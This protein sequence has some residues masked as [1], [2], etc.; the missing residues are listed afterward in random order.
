MTSPGD[1]EQ[2]N[3]TEAMTR[4]AGSAV[5]LDVRNPDETAAGRAREAM[6][7]P[8]PELGT[9]LDELDPT[10]PI[11]AVCKAGG[12]SQMAAELL[13]AAGFDV[14]NLAG[15]M[16]AW[17]SAGLDVIDNAGEPGSIK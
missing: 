6:L 13:A 10:V 5:L 12:R 16:Q 14:V 17:A 11:V 1:I 4:I 2:I 15:G 8:L 3:P 9:R 7:I